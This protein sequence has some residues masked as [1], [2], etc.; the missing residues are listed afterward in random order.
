MKL[1]ILDD[2]CYYC[3]CLHHL[4]TPPV[5]NIQVYQ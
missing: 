3:R 1:D 4:L 5:S 2:I